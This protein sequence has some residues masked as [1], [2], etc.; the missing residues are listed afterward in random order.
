MSRTV[1]RMP[2]AGFVL[3]C[4][5]R[6]RQVAHRLL[7]VAR[8]PQYYPYK[9]IL[10]YFLSV[11]GTLVI[12]GLQVAFSMVDAPLFSLFFWCLLLTWFG[13]LG[14]GIVT[15][16]VSTAV[17]NFFFLTPL[18][19]MSLNGQSGYFSLLFALMTLTSVYMLSSMQHYAAVQKTLLAKEQKISHQNEMLAAALKKAVHARDDFLAIAGHELKTP[20]TALSLQAQSWQRRYLKHAD[21]EKT[22]SPK[23]AWTRQVRGL[24]RLGTLIDELL[25]VS[26]LNREKLELHLEPLDLRDI[27]EDV[28]SRY[29]EIAQNAKSTLT[30]DLH[31]SVQGSYDRLRV[32]QIFINLLTNALKYG[33]G[34]P[35][36]VALHRE[37]NVAVIDF[38]DNGRGISEHDQKRIFECFHRSNPDDSISGFGLGLWIVQ[39]VVVACGGSIEVQSALG[40]GALFR[41]KL[42]LEVSLIFMESKKN[43]IKTLSQST[44]TSGHAPGSF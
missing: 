17:G 32:E 21:V 6:P 19:Q 33:A 39:Q 5:L 11:A 20:I 43:P 8:R 23:D 37:K 4:L 28:V 12:A 22:R 24:Q 38:Q 29:S 42:P 1:H 16:V 26:G 41:V 25:D 30:L 13:G 3:Q 34:K 2:V 9:V 35:V 40:Q 36:R 18:G 44:L 7:Q 15:S 27:I 14:A 10:Y 31:E